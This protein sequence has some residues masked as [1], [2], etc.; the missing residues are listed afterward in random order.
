MK[1]HR[2][3]FTLIE[4]LVVIAII[5]ILAAIL[6]PVF[7]KARERAKTATCTSNMSQ[8]G[9]A[10]MMYT[11]DYDG[12][13]VPCGINNPSKGAG[14]VDMWMDLLQPYVKNY[15]IGSCPSAP[16]KDAQGIGMDHE[17]VGR[18]IVGNPPSQV[19]LRASKVQEP[20]ATVIFA[21]S[22]WLKTIKEPDPDKWEDKKPYAKAS[23][24]MVPS[25]GT[26]YTDV[27]TGYRVIGRHG[28]RAVCAFMDGHVKAMR[29]SELGFQDPK[30]G[31]IINLGDP[32]ALWDVPDYT[33]G[34][35]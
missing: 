34:S 9:K 29:P 33:H 18:W 8:V 12:G 6:F 3:A 25:N 15:D 24:F 27:V 32:R 23:V 35:Y 17:Q 31:A 2:R 1:T 28:G 19:Y 16:G 4:L 10:T 13:V 26:H 11:D 20:A 22:G 30:T 7:A 21:D 5:A 14:G